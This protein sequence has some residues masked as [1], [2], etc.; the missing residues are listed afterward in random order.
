MQSSLDTSELASNAEAVQT[1]FLL[2]IFIAVLA[3]CVAS[4]YVANFLDYLAA[5]MFSLNFV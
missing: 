1:C 2:Y 4:C 3:L 5:H